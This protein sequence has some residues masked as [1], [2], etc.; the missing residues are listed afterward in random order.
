MKEQEKIY[1]YCPHCE[2]KTQIIQINE[3]IYNTPVILSGTFSKPSVSFGLENVVDFYVSNYICSQ[4]E[5]IVGKE[6][7]KNIYDVDDLISY[8]QEKHEERERKQK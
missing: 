2:E 6:T 3:G 4:C 7:G 5:N 1:Y 8:L